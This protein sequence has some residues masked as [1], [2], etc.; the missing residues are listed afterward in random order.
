MVIVGV[1]EMVAD[2]KHPPPNH[3][4][5]FQSTEHFPRP[6]TVIT[7]GSAVVSVRLLRTCRISGDVF[8][9]MPAGSD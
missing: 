5:G 9:M 1:R 8:W 7:R 3:C 6:S 4:A 2:R